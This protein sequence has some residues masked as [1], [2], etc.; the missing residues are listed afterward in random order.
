MDDSSFRN[1]QCY[2]HVVKFL[3]EINGIYWITFSGPDFPAEN[4]QGRIRPEPFWALQ[5]MADGLDSTAWMGASNIVTAE[6]LDPSKSRFF[7]WFLPQQNRW[8]RWPGIQWVCRV[9]RVHSAHQ[10]SE[11]LY[12]KV[13]PACPNLMSCLLISISSQPPTPFSLSA[14]LVIQLSIF[15]HRMEFNALLGRTFEPS[16][17]SP[18]TL[19]TICCLHSP[20][21]PTGSFVSLWGLL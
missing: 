9:S 13:P 6:F 2:V 1:K 15:S 3:L 4:Q 19:L 11:D 18:L 16:V 12:E 10:R 14:T 7:L 21:K 5:A 20:W 17:V 8:F